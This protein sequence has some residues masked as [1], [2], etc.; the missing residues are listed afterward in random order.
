MMRFEHKWINSP[1]RI[2][3]NLD[4]I[5]L[6][7]ISFIAELKVVRAFFSVKL[8]P[9]ESDKFMLYWGT[10]GTFDNSISRQYDA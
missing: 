9:V 7:I 10:N 4:V 5:F 2:F 3:I 1:V 6:A 8:K